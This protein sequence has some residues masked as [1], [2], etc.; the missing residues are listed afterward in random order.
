[1]LKLQ[2]RMVEVKFEIKGKEV[3]PEGMK[4][5]LDVIFLEH[6]RGE[7]RDSLGSAQCKKHDCRPKVKIKGES[8]DNL[9]YEVSGCC[10]QFIEEVEEKIK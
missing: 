2:M 8:L 4:D 9:T 5:V 1:M 6:L 7:V 3:E 10:P